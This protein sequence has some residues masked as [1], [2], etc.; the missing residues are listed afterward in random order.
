MGNPTVGFDDGFV[1]GSGDGFDPKGFDDK[2]SGFDDAINTSEVEDSFGV[3]PKASPKHEDKLIKDG[4]DLIQKDLEYRKKSREYDRQQTTKDRPQVET[5]VSMSFVD[6]SGF[7]GGAIHSAAIGSGSERKQSTT[8]RRASLTNGGAKDDDQR[9]AVLLKSKRRSSV[10]AT[11]SSPDGEPQGSPKK[12]EPKFRNR[13]SSLRGGGNT[14]PPAEKQDPQ[15]PRHRFSRRH[16]LDQGDSHH[17]AERRA[18]RRPTENKEGTDPPAERRGSAKGNR[19]ESR[20]S[21]TESRGSG[22]PRRIQSLGRVRRPVQAAAS[23]TTLEVN[24]IAPQRTT[25]G[26]RRPDRN[27]D[28]DPAAKVSLELKN[29][30]MLQNSPSIKSMQW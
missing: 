19:T 8:S 11:T 4:N 29:K 6:C 25:S 14:H 17:S 30:G 2:I 22:K 23:S 7:P 28:Q 12:E 1:G 15:P 18:N 10:D 16:S 13:R 21:R 5:K 9:R 27:T 24:R 3:T 20:R 26:M